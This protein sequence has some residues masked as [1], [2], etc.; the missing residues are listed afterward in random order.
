M[1]LYDLYDF[2]QP[3]H[4]APEISYFNTI[5]DSSKKDFMV[6]VNTESLFS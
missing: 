1:Y 4:L 2:R 6:K 3:T 5:K